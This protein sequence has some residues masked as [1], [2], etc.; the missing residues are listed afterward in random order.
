MAVSLQEQ[1]ATSMRRCVSESQVVGSGNGGSSVSS[2]TSTGST[3]APDAFP[4]LANGVLQELGL[5]PA[6]TR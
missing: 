4:S 1:L 5:D 6:V 3:P 2:E